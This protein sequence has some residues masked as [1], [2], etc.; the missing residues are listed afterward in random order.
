MQE[1]SNMNSDLDLNS[2]NYFLPEEL[3]ASIPLDIRHHS[4]LLAFD[5]RNNQISHHQIIDLPGLLS[6]DTLLVF[7]QSK[8]IPGRLLGKKITGGAVEILILQKVP[9]GKGIPCMIKTSG[10]KKVGDQ[11]S[12]EE[13]INA[14]ISEVVGDGTFK[15][16]FKDHTF[17]EAL[18]LIGMVP[19]PPYIR[20]GIADQN[21][22]KR[23]QTVYAKEEGS[24]AAPTAGL[25]FS[26]ELLKEL[27]NHSVDTAFVTL[28]VGPGTFQP[29]K[30]EKISDHKMHKEF[31]TVDNENLKKLNL[32]KKA[33]KKIIS[34]GTT[35]LRVLE[36]IYNDEKSLFEFENQGLGD[37]DIFLY[38]GKKVN[39][40][41]GL[42]TNFH[43]PKSSLLMLVSCLIGR[44]KCLELYESAK[45]K[46]YRFYSY[47][48]AMFI[49]RKSYD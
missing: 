37:T 39:S 5:Q 11:Y 28:H 48:D 36:S 30:S 12:F 33:G 43:L 32:A 45:S 2:Y 19:I 40:I 34:V 17:D 49:K 9:N 23:Y 4:K 21:D 47:G 6:K 15:I 18:G 25:H 26:K 35:T 8:V 22:V 24:V 38:P 1:H 42:I 14:E 46:K 27:E 44:D 13:N 31:F 7:N 41:D 3:I 20:K 29:V 16:R 10:K